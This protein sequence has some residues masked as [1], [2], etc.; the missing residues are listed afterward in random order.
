MNSLKDLRLKILKFNEAYEKGSPIVDDFVYDFYKKKLE[1]LEQNEKIK[2][3][4]NV[5]SKALEP[6]SHL[7][8][9]LSLNHDFGKNSIDGFIKKIEKQIDPFPMVAEL[10]IDGVSVIAT[11]EN[12]KIICLKTR[13]NGFLGENISHLIPFLNIPNKIYLTEHLEIRFEAYFNKKEFENPRNAAAGILMKKNP[14][15]KLALLN[16]APHNLY[17]NSLIWNS[18]IQLREIFY[19][20]HLNCIEP[21]KVCYNIQDCYQYFEEI[22]LLKN[23]LSHEIDGVVFKVDSKE[24]QNVLGSTAKAPKFAF[25]I[26]FS[27]SFNISEITQIDFQVGRLGKITP[28]ATLTPTFI[29]NRSISK[30]TLNN[31][32]DLMKKNFAIGDIV[33]I[34]MAGEVIPKI[35]EIIEKS[36]NLTQIPVLCPSCNTKLIEDFCPN[37]WNCFQQKLNRLIYFANKNGLNI[38][39]LGEA[40]IQFFVKENILN[41]PFDFFMLKQNIYNISYTPNWLAE[42]SFAKIIESVEKSKYCTLEQFIVSI[43]LPNIAK[44][45]AKEINLKFKS[46]ENFLNANIKS[47]KF[48]GEKNAQSVFEYK[49]KEKF[50]INKTFEFLKTDKKYEKV[51]LFNFE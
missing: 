26:K 43:G 23:N 50:W 19:K 39:N 24:K 4:E 3:S 40:Q 32:N 21:Y 45:K 48:L 17:S 1:I 51:S 10:K 31:L 28:V 42:K 36:N 16:F 30:A 15:S 12:Q 18:Y 47:L 44:T 46:L 2:I 27:N 49:E 22:N 7:F 25:A 14:D 20:M 34:E 8:P 9:I 37:S 33:K 38:K 6:S 35:T 13:G 29:N 5:G 41:Y 11:Y